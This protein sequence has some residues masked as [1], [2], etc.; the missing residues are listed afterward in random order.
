MRSTR[1]AAKAMTY[2]VQAARLSIAA[3]LL[4]LTNH[5]ER[6]AEKVAEVEQRDQ[7]QNLFNH[8]DLMD[9]DAQAE[10][11]YGGEKP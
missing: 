1:R 8:P 3:G 10:H 2:S 7:D 6:F 11:W 5:L 9:L 4:R